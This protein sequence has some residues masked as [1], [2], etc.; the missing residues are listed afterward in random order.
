M[1]CPTDLENG[2]Q[3]VKRTSVIGHKRLEVESL[4]DIETSNF[5]ALLTYHFLILDKQDPMY[6]GA[7]QLPSKYLAYN[8]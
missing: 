5:K 6:S 8:I 7:L 1:W 2:K 4:G 3:L